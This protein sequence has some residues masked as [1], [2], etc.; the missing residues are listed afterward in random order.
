[1]ALSS[2][3]VL[4]EHTGPLDA[5]QHLFR[6]G[7]AFT[8]IAAVRAGTVKTYVVDDRGREHVL[9]F[10]IP[11][12]IIGLGA[13]HRSRY[14]CNAVALD[15]VFLCR[16]RFERLA[17]LATRLPALQKHLF[18]LMSEDIG[19]AGLMTGDFTAEERVSAFLVSLSRRYRRQG[20]PSTSLTLPM[21]RVDIASHLRLAPE[22]VSRVLRRLRAKGLLKLDGRELRFLDM[23]GLAARAASVLR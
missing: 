14:P 21:T 13:I 12:E 11:G 5:G 2:L 10:H 20:F 23:P 3:H 7:D 22:T 8:A 19:K 9:G 6:D 4:V 1:M 18:E 16:F 17:Q 15:E